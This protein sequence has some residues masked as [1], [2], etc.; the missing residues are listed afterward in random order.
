MNYDLKFIIL[1]Y[2]LRFLFLH[3][4]TT[5]PVIP[6]CSFD[7]FYAAA[8]L[9]RILEECLAV[10]SYIK[11]HGRHFYRYDLTG[12]DINKCF[13]L[14]EPVRIILSFCFSGDYL[15]RE[16]EPLKLGHNFNLMSVESLLGIVS[17]C[18]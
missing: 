15:K 10:K 17:I 4:F 14:C 16:G 12:C 7:L 8:G 1:S 3:N 5:F 6:F 13:G 11:H 18:R 2:I 9:F